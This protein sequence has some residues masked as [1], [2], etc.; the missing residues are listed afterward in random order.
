MKNEPNDSG[1]KEK[2]I[3]EAFDLW[4]QIGYGKFH[5]EF[6]DPEAIR[7]QPDPTL[8]EREL[9]NEW[10]Q[11]S[12]PYFEDFRAEKA[13]LSIGELSAQVEQLR[14]V[15]GRSWDTF[16]R[17]LNSHGKPPPKADDP[18]VQELLNHLHELVSARF[19]DSLVPAA[20]LAFRVEDV[21][22]GHG[23]E[24][25]GDDLENAKP[26]AALTPNQKWDVLESYIDWEHFQEQ[27]LDQ[28]DAEKISH[29]VRGKP[30]DRWL[31]GT[32]YTASLQQPSTGQNL[33]SRLNALRHELDGRD[34]N[35]RD[36]HDKSRG[37]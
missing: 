15:S 33:D 19:V 34:G 32:S 21:P 9:R 18:M 35:G 2:L 30:P 31:E 29:N 1:K 14:A 7:Q 6:F 36:D 4:T 27:G 17:L 13:S 10:Q 16:Q 28:G 26:F 23:A 12:E 22:T 24:S 5:A 3:R 8:R 20:G 11:F 37:C 25:F